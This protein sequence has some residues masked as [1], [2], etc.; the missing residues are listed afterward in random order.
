M[1]S[2]LKEQMSSTQGL[3][4]KVSNIDRAQHYG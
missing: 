3:E 2:D 1:I 4:K